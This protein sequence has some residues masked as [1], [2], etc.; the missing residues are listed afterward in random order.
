MWTW[1][2]TREGALYSVLESDLHPGGSGDKKKGSDEIGYRFWE[3]H[4]ENSVDNGMEAGLA[5]GMK[6][7]MIAHRRKNED[8]I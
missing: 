1:D 2:M 8:L 7:N 3:T 6:A 4:F 5:E